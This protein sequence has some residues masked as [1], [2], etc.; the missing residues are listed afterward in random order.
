MI[1]KIIHYIWLG[2]KPL[3]AKMQECLDSWKRNMP[4]Y[5]IMVWDDESIKEIDSIFMQEA[6]CEK[7]W[8]FA[9]DVIRLYAVNKYGGIYFDTDVYVYKSFDSLLVD[10]AFIGRENSFHIINQNTVNFLTTCCFGAEP[11]NAFIKRCLDYYDDRHFITSF[12]RSLPL[13]LRL[14]TKLNSEIFTVLASQIGYDPSV[15]KD[16]I[17]QCGDSLVVY[18]I[19]YFDS[20]G[21]KSDTYCQHLALGTWREHNLI[22]MD[23][24]WS[25]KVSWRVWAALDRLAHKFNRTILKLN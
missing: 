4:S 6:I 7:K 8:A 13:E 22:E 11:G 5:N 21:V 20:V 12:D 15:L 1:P 3:P 25:Y 23:Y 9:S 14:D 17:Q 16:S 2:N 19:R 18:P 24:T 10:S